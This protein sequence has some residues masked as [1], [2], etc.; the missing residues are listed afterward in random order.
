ME[1]TTIMPVRGAASSP[2]AADAQS[3]VPS[4]SPAVDSS[5]GE[6]EPARGESDN[7]PSPREKRPRSED[8]LATGDEVRPAPKRARSTSPVAAPPP[9]RPQ[10]PTPRRGR[11]SSPSVLATPVQRLTQPPC[12]PSAS[13]SSVFSPAS[14]GSGWSRNPEIAGSFGYFRTPAL[15]PLPFLLV[16]TASVPTEDELRQ[17]ARAQMEA[18]TAGQP[19][20]TGIIPPAYYRWDRD[21]SHRPRVWIRDETTGAVRP[22]RML[23]D[24]I[25]RQR[26]AAEAEDSEEGEESGEESEGE[27]SEGEEGEEG[28]EEGENGEEGEEVE[29]KVGG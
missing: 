25:K 11:I 3:P 23:D 27:V 16:N 24:D 22:R 4:S 7:S 8:D 5:A 10:P 9:A 6:V 13:A 1:F 29:E 14:M 28:E 18:E 12:T 15:S 20:G 21:H 17:R 2:P 26:R 19:K